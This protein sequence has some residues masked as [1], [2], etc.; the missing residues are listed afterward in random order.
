MS[1]AESVGFISRIRGPVV[2]VRFDP[3]NTPKIFDTI[4]IAHLPAIS[5]QTDLWLE[6]QV[7]ERT[8]ARC[9]AL[10]STDGLQ[11]GTPAI[12]RFQP[13]TVPVGPGVLGRLLDGLGRPLDKLGPVEAVRMDPIHRQ[14]P[15]FAEQLRNFDLLE[16]GIKSIDLLSPFPKGGKIGLFGGAGVGKS[17][18]LAELFYSVVTKHNG[19]IVFAGVGER[20]GE[21]AALW[22]NVQKNKVLRENSVLVFGQM[23][24]PPGIRYR[25]AL[26]ATTIAEYFR[27]DE[28]RDVLFVLDNVYRYIQA[29]MEVSA[30]LG[31]LPSHVGYQPTLQQDIGYLEERLV[32]THQA[33]IT[34]V[35]AIYVPADDITDPGPVS[36]FS[37][38]DAHVELDRN[39]AGIGLHPAI[40]PLKSS[41]RLLTPHNSAGLD[42]EHL[43]T[44][45]R[46]KSLLQET[47]K[48]M[49]YVIIF[50]ID[51]LE[52]DQKLA[53]WRSRKLRFFLSQPFFVMQMFGS[54]IPGKFVK[55]QDTVSGCKAIMDGIYDDYREEDFK[56]LG[57]MVEI[58]DEH[59]I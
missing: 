10:G 36:I 8:T 57:A 56:N 58:H 20:V 43:E 39:L 12:T 47:N 14:P 42:T 32:S 13:I 1:L 18:L 49:D 38:L 7:V 4:H 40:N 28:C 15:P 16:T 59:R 33:S 48:I 19:I 9:I 29:G 21:G 37:H 5:Q 2:D 53:L 44:V 11:I 35:Q 55:R 31:R 54:P 46:V 24:E 41:S 51:G 45:K 22:Q 23:N 6:C 3:G 25:A 17:T 34:S 50:G 52:E 26:T 30:L 27:D